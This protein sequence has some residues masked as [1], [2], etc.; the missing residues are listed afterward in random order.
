MKS[1]QTTNSTF[2]EKLIKQIKNNLLIKRNSE[3]QVYRKDVVIK[4]RYQ[5]TELGKEVKLFREEI[6]G[7]IIR[8]KRGEIRT[9]SKY[10]RIRAKTFIRNCM[11][12]DSAKHD[13]RPIIS[14]F[15]PDLYITLTYPTELLND[16]KSS[17]KQLS[18]FLAKLRIFSNGKIHYIWVKEYQKRGAIH[19]HLLLQFENKKFLKNHGQIPFISALWSYI[20]SQPNKSFDANLIK[21]FLHR[22]RINHSVNTIKNDF[23]LFDCL[24]DVIQSKTLKKTLKASTNVKFIKNH[25]DTEEA[26][27]YLGKYLTKTDYFHSPK[28]RFWGNSQ[29]VKLIPLYLGELKPSQER[30]IVKLLSRKRVMKFEKNKLINATQ[31]KTPNSL[32]S[33]TIRNASKTFL[34]NLTKLENFLMEQDNTLQTYILLD[35]IN[36]KFND[37][38]F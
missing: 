12:I 7:P 11:I 37:V 22:F 29:T 25:R 14:E 27:N 30:I 33:T 19:Y 8:R 35:S 2:S 24:T 15:Q 13:S 6:H 1:Y 32:F 26:I 10:S 5:E 3:I 18:Y 4:R 16:N 21:T 31:T 38:P 23:T 34:R 20:I 9:V 17:K 36:P 28:G